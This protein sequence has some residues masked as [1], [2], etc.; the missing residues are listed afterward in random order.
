M[1]RLFVAVEPPESIKDQLLGLME[2]VPGARWQTPEQLHLTLRFIGEVD[3]RTA[4]DIA[5]ALLRL[6]HPGFEVALAGVGVFERRGRPEAIWAGLTPHAPLRVVHDKVDRA[7]AMAGVAPD[8]RAYH[9]HITLARLNVGSG[10]VGGWLAAAG[11]LASEPWRVDELTLYES[12]LGKSG[13]HYEP[14]LRVALGG[15]IATEAVSGRR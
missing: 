13:A 4:E 7:L 14:V 9:P 6:A 15:A 12:H 11:A 1:H 8:T 5:E 10:P 2:G 3:G